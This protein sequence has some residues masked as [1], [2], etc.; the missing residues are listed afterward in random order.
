MPVHQAPRLNQGAGSRTRGRP[1]GAKNKPKGTALAIVLNDLR[2]KIGSVV[3]P[4]DMDYLVKTL[5]G[6]EKSELPKDMDI[7]LGMALKALLP[8]LADEIKIG[9]LTREGTQRLA[10]VKELLALRFQMEKREKGDDKPN[11][12]TFITN[13]FQQRGLGDARFAELFGPGGGDQLPPKVVTGL[14]P[15]SADGDDAEADEVGAVPDRVSERPVEVQS[16]REVTTDRLLVDYL[17]GSDPQD[18]HDSV[19]GTERSL[20][21]PEGS[22]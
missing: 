10:T 1:L 22:G 21:Q 18:H 5:E 4:E 16:S 8:I 13:V 7:V 3:T 6:S 2:S 20:H 14:L 11:A 17:G 12:V 9:A 15:R 19:E